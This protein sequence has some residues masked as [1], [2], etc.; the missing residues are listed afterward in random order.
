[1][2]CAE[3]MELFLRDHHGM[4]KSDAKLCYQYKCALGEPVVYDKN[5]D[6]L[7]DLYKGKKP[8]KEEMKKEEIDL[9][10]EAKKMGPIWRAEIDESLTKVKDLFEELQPVSFRSELWD[11]Y[12]G[13]YGDVLED[14][15]FLFC[16]EESVPQME[17][18]CRLDHAEKGDYEITFDNLHENL[19]HQ[20]SL[21][22][23]MYLAV[24]YLVLLLEL[25]KREEKPEWELKILALLGDILT[26]D[27][28][29]CGGGEQ[30]DLPD[31]VWESYQRSVKKLPKMAKD[32][33]GR[34]MD[35]VQK[36]DFYV[37]I[38][39]LSIL[40]DRE[41]AFEMLLG[42]FEQ[43]PVECPECEYY[44]EAMECDGL[45]AEECLEEIEPAEDVI[46]KW[47]GKD[48]SDT[49]VW[50]SNLIH[51]VDEEQSWKVRYYYGTYTCPEC[52]SK[53]T[54]IEWMKESRRR[55]C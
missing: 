26:T 38:D 17:K 4:R 16:K 35:L 32:F 30:G 11:Q 51:M 45:E 13:A 37:C 31:E 12:G 21:Y 48:Y 54:L 25:K 10:E 28:P 47:D 5:D 2:D 24:P 19:I 41:A 49:Y 14:L 18:L 7:L 8:V 50:F 6:R 36:E 46:G 3:Y 40:A 23:G 27:I 22:P 44:D 29:A 20:L 55:E 9:E 15:L 33:L 39:L 1:M 53:G 34:Q 42:G 52:G 43:C